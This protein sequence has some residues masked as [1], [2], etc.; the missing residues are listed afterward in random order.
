MQGLDKF[1]EILAATD[2]VMV[3]RGDLGMEIPPEKCVLSPS[4]NTTRTV[5]R[6]ADASRT[7]RPQRQHTAL[8]HSRPRCKLWPVP[9]HARFRVADSGSRVAHNTAGVQC[10]YAQLVPPCSE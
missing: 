3:A 9:G 5:I 7:V 4:P 8:A 6:H 10:V 1:D 2:G